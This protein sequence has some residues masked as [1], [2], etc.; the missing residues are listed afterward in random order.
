ME[1]T[2]FSHSPTVLLRVHKGFDL[3][4][5][6]T[7][8]TP[9]FTGD[10]DAGKELLD[11]EDEQLTELQE[12]LFAQSRFGARDSVLLVL[13]AMDTGGKGGI[14]RH[15]IGAA[16]PQGIHHK[17]FK[18]PTAEEQSK[19][20]LWR[21]E[22]ELPAPGIIGVFDRSH[23]EDVLVQRVRKL[24]PANEIE[25]RYSLIRDFEARVAAGG[26]RIIKVMLHISKDEQKDRLQER[27]DRPDKHWKYNPGDVDDRTFWDQYQ[28]AYQ[29]A[30]ERTST[31][32]APW[33]VVPADKK[34][35]ARIAVQQLLIDVLEDINPQWPTADFDVAA[36]KKRLAES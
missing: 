24:S 8:S 31:D 15:V 30:L 36:E 3:S 6:H 35:Y 13:Q 10:K 16:D 32:S 33:Y 5:V 17:A 4:Q 9:G 20:F 27:L 28:Q 21:I 12:K 11:R 18:A 19:G 34:W 7:G 2:A 14:V 23:Y 1:T 22:K 26:T 29:I 25:Q